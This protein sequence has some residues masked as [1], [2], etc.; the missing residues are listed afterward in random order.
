MAIRGGAAG[1]LRPAYLFQLLWPRISFWDL[2]SYPCGFPPLLCYTRTRQKGSCHVFLFGHLMQRIPVR[3]QS[4]ASKQASIPKGMIEWQSN[5]RAAQAG[6]SWPCTTP[7][8][9]IPSALAPVRQVTLKTNKGQISRW[10]LSTS[11]RDL[12]RARN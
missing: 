4:R 1:R 6:E 9:V 11:S 10:R 12:R 8:Y 2:R 5:R 7:Y 3:P